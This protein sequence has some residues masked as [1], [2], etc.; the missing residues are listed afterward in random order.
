MKREKLPIHI[1]DMHVQTVKMTFLTKEISNQLIYMVKYC[2]AFILLDLHHLEA[3]VTNLSQFSR[4]SPSFT[5]I[6]RRLVLV[7][8]NLDP[9]V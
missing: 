7:Y 5:P 4:L 2:L 3:A 8:A 9:N 1:A 6:Y